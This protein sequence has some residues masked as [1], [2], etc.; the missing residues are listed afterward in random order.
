MNPLEDKAEEAEESGDIA[1]ALKLWKGLAERER[2]PVLFCRYGRAALKLERWD[3]AEDAFAQ[4]LRLEPDF[5]LAME[6][7]GNLWATR[8]DKSDVEALD[9]AKEW[10][11][12]ALR[13]ERSARALTFLGATYRAL[14][15]YAAARDALI[16]AIQIDPNYEEALYNLAVLEEKRE[17][18]RSIELL[19]RAIE[20]DPNYFLAHQELGTVLH[21]SGDLPGAE[22][23]FRRSLEIEPGDLFSLLYLANV[24]GV[25]GKDDEAEQTYRQVMSLHPN[26][27]GAAKFFANFLESIGKDD[28]A[29][30]LRAPKTP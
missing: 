29:A 20:I 21:R 14:G 30:A 6:G 12:R 3:E 13:Q 10:F 9:T 24:L 1:L 15:N 18:P 7:M 16:E 4:A 25:Q 11:L 23:H 27:E 5:A 26:D 17:A 28:E 19:E 8:T 22:Y 2:D